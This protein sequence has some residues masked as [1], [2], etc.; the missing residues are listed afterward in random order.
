MNTTESSNS[1]Q[2]PEESAVE[3]NWIDLGIHTFIKIAIVC[4]LIWWFY[5]NE[6]SG[7]VMRWV[8]DSSWSHGFLIP[9]FS[10]YFLNQN[11]DDIIALKD[12][13]KPSWFVGMP[14][15]VFLLFILYPVNFVGLKFMYGKPLIMIATIGAIVLFLGGWKLLKYAW[16]PVAYLFFAVPLPN[17]IYF[18]LTNPM[19][20]WAAQVSGFVLGLV[21]EVETT[22]RGVVI[23]VTY[24]GESIESALNVADACSGMRLLMAFVALGVAMAYLHWRPIW[25]R[26]V[27]LCSTIP[28]AIFCNF[29]RVT[30]TGFIYVLGDP[31][32]AKGIYHDMLGMLMLPLAFF[33]YGGLA[34]LMTNLFVDEDEDSTKED[35]II[36]RKS[37]VEQEA[38]E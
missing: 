37:P 25:Q 5:Q 16:L 31:K 29:V 23:D 28:I 32:Y 26:L 36:R 33:L 6:I 35:I 8:K 2:S 7:I 19:R 18:Q 20:A 3:K 27:L 14:A 17:G 21:P 15:L 12:E 10:L 34:W 1:I 4:V 9:L 13:F 24:K 11:K 38:S 30:V 22:V